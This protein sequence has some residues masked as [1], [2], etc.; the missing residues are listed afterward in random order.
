MQQDQLQQTVKKILEHYLAG[1]KLR[2]TP[3]RFAV[4]EVIY[5]Q[6]EHFDV[7]ALFELMKKKK[8][9][10]SRATLYNTI[11]HLLASDL[12]TRHQ[13][14]KNLAMFERSY[15]FKQHDH[16]ICTDCDKVME[17][18]DPRIQQIQAMMG[19]I[20]HFSVTHHSLNLFGKCLQLSQTGHCEHLQKK[21]VNLPA[22]QKKK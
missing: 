6:E 12:I 15:A 1:K 10:I 16:L 19:E 13:F 17:F 8:Y 21:Q 5:Q 3:E 11:E 9:R 22:N 7:D 14:G 4:L 20:L 2:K 18:C